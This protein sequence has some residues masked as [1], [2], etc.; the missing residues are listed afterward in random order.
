MSQYYRITIIFFV[1]AMASPSN[2]S[3]SAKVTDSP[4]EQVTTMLTE[5]AAS[6][7]TSILHH[8]GASFDLH[9]FT[10]ANNSCQQLG[11]ST[12]GTGH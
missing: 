10:I 4:H 11:S 2:L 7:A 9:F 8:S 5:P 3:G 12:F 1:T 6:A